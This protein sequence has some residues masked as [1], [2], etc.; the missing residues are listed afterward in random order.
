MQQA[1]CES[2]EMT[3]GFQGCTCGTEISS[4][5]IH[6]SGKDEWIASMLDFLAQISV[7]PV[8]AQAL[9]ERKAGCGEKLSDVLTRYD[10]ENCSWK[11]PQL[12]LL[13]DSEEF[14]ETWPSW[15]TMRN[16]VCY[17]RPSLVPRTYAPGGGVLQDWQTP[18]ADDAVNRKKGKWNSRGEPK[19]SAQVMMPTP[20]VCG[21]YNR[22]GASK[23]SGDG[24]ATYVAKWP[25][26]RCHDRKKMSLT[27]MD[28]KSPCLA[29]LVKWPTNEK[30]GG[31]LNPTWVEWLM[32]WPIGHTELKHWGTAKFPSRRQPRIES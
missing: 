20:T 9:T 7:S 2:D 29:A 1:S 27:E 32:G 19:L 16:G 11:T 10:R 25:T 12:S 6:P 14:S 17:Q 13:G 4:C 21:N 23:T 31:T 5:S 3:D 8:M 28:R 15:G 24:L 18:V 30:V 22:K 26:P